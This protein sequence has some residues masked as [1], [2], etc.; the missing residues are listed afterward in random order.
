MLAA[1]PAFAQA[2]MT[3]QAYEEEG[4]ARMQTMSTED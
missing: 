2:A 4:A 1:S 3:R